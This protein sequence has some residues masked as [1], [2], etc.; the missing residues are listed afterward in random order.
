MKGC[1]KETLAKSNNIIILIKKA[2]FPSAFLMFFI[3]KQACFA[4]NVYIFI[5]LDLTVFFPTEVVF[6]FQKNIFSLFSTS[7]SFDYDP[8]A[9][10]RGLR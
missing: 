3:L 2:L 6:S 10:D 9:Y 5:Y 8:K 1:S 7:A 4:A